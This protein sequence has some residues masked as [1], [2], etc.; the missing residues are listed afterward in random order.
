MVLTWQVFSAKFITRLFLATSC[1]A[2]VYAKLRTV[3][4][5]FPQFLLRLYF[6]ELAIDSRA[7]GLNCTI[8]LNGENKPIARF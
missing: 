4:A 2:S 5:F 8:G 7:G 3:D 1:I 6:V